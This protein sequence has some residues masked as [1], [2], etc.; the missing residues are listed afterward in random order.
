MA[1]GQNYSALAGLYRQ[2]EL[3]YVI[4]DERDIVRVRTNYRLEDVYL[5]RLTTATAEKARGLFLDYIKS[6]NQLHERTTLPSN[7]A[8]IS[9][10]S[11]SV[12]R[13]VSAIAVCPFKV[14][15]APG[16]CAMARNLSAAA[17]AAWFGVYQ[18]E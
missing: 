4:G 15:T 12:R 18:L 16:H 2:F 11:S 9:P 14:P 5:Y 3:Y 7:V 1:R 17:I 8:V 10:L 13:G 6:A